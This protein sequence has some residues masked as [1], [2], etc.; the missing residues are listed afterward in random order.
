MHSPIEAL[1]LIIQNVRVALE[2]LRGYQPHYP[3]YHLKGRVVNSYVKPLNRQQY[4]FCQV[5]QEMDEFLVNII[6]P[7]GSATF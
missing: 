4:I 5:H 6:R 1:N 7:Q 3:I 2:K